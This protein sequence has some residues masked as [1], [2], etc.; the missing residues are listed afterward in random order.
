MNELP[1]KLI[2]KKIKAQNEDVDKSDE[3]AAMLKDTISIAEHQLKYIES[4]EDLISNLEDKITYYENLLE[5]YRF[6]LDSRDANTSDNNVN[7]IDN[8]DISN[9]DTSKFQIE[10]N[11]FNRTLALRINLK[12]KRRNR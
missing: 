9:K 10:F 1:K 2:Y 8:S 12:H 6:D 7:S 11:P 4:L 5:I 3:L